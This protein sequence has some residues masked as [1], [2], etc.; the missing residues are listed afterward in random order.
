VSAGQ[1][2]ALVPYEISTTSGPVPVIVTNG[3][4]SNTV[5][6]P[7]A[8]TSPGVFST[9]LT[10]A[11]A[12]AITHNA[13][14]ALVTP[15]NP[16]VAGE[17]LVAYLTGLGALQTPVVDGNAPASGGTDAAVIGSQ[18]QVQ[19]DGVTS[20]TI[21]YAGIN[22]V[23]PGLYQIDFQMPQIPDHQQNVN[24]LILAGTAGTQEVQL[25]AQ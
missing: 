8:A 11:G 4:A 10:G 24:I 23:Y 18:V 25:Y 13:T 14:G 17:V 9:D 20:P 1:I 12:G 15:N 5:N 3:T 22:P 16:A 2:N 19:V 7:V 21:Y 6:V